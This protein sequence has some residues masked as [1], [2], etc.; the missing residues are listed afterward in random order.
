[1]GVQDDPE[2]TV[3]RR[4]SENTHILTL[5]AVS[6]DAKAVVAGDFKTQVRLVHVDPL[7]VFGQRGFIVGTI[8]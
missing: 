8:T 4:S 6:F 2:I 5:D 1:M 7:L 3:P